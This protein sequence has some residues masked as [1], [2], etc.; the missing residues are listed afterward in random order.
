VISDSLAL[1]Y[2]PPMDLRGLVGVVGVNAGLP[3][4]VAQKTNDPRR[5][6]RRDG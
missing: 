1:L 2:V 6:C 3:H 4:L 5:S